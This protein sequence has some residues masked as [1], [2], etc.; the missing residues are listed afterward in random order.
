MERLSQKAP[1]VK[2]TD[3]QKSELAEVDSLYA[4][5]LAERELL[6]KDQL[7]KAYEKG[8]AAEVEQLEKQIV[9]DR[10]TLAE[11]KEFKKEKIRERNASK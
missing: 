1:S 6:V 2:L 8:D 3:A 11:E 5:K 4:A 10:K 7:R 9:S